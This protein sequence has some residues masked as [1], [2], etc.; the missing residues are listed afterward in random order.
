MGTTKQYV[1][2]CNAIE[3]L[4]SKGKEKLNLNLIKPLILTTNLQGLLGI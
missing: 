3:S 1:S 4:T 2:G